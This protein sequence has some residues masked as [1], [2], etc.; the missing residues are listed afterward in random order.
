M[1]FATAVTISACGDQPSSAAATSRSTCDESHRAELERQ[2]L[3]TTHLIEQRRAAFEDRY[4]T[5]MPADNVW[6]AGRC[7]EQAALQKVLIALDEVTVRPGAAVRG[8][9]TPDNEETA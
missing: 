9:G 8:A 1:S 3:Q 4:G 5:P 2:L 6:L 7:K